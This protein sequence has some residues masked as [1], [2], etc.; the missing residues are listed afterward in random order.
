MAGQSGPLA[1]LATLGL[2]GPDTTYVHC[3]TLRDD[4]LRRM[5]DSGGSA[6]VSPEVEMNMGHGMPATG[7]LLEHGIRPSLS[8]DVVTG[9]GGDMFTV[10]RMCL[11]MERALVNQRALQAGTSVD[12]LSLTTRDVLEF[13]T[14]EGARACG[15]ADR[16]GS[17]SPGKQ[18]DLILVRTDGLNL[19]PLNNPVGALVVATHP[20]DVDSVFVAGRA[21]K[22]H[23][24]LLYPDLA[25]LRTRAVASRDFL[26]ARAGLQP[27]LDWTLPFESRW[28][29]S[30]LAAV[31]EPRPD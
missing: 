12:R 25:G 7:R 31:P 9:I 30:H 16:V 5:A 29:Q 24:R 4:E 27:G 1:K 2:L 28:K 8:V 22:R 21:L 19:T 6:S 13:A 15:L 10:M 23:G 20:G 18:A 17:L 14:L 3:N 26:L 11:A